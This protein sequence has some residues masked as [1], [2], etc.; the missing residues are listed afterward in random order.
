M[1]KDHSINNDFFFENIAMTK[2]SRNKYS[3][4]KYL[5]KNYIHDILNLG[6]EEKFN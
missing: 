1:V 6:E 2:A 3:L 4:K 5:K